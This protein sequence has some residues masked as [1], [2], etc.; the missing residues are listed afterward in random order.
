MDEVIRHLKESK[1]HGAGQ[2]EEG[3][4]ITAASLVMRVE[5]VDESEPSFVV[6][7]TGDYIT[8]TGLLT[9]GQGVILDSFQ[10]AEGE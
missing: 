1:I 9:L 7:H 4:M 10:E 2:L 6:M 8:A 3:D 5:R